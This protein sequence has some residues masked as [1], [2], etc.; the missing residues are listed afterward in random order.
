MNK[1]SQIVNLIHKII[2]EP[3]R[4]VNRCFMPSAGEVKAK[5][6]GLVLFSLQLQK[7]NVRTIHVCDLSSFPGPETH[8]RC[9]R[10]KTSSLLDFCTNILGISWSF[11]VI[12]YQVLDRD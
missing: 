11:S 2:I 10:Y 12:A 4:S 5:T 8:A 6:Q 1:I 9:K 3:M 7:R